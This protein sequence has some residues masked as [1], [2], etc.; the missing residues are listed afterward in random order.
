[1]EPGQSAE[2]SQGTLVQG[3][4]GAGMLKTENKRVQMKKRMHQTGNA[5]MVAQTSAGF[6]KCC[7]TINTFPSLRTGKTR[8]T[9]CDKTGTFQSDTDIKLAIHLVSVLISVLYFSPNNISYVTQNNMNKHAEIK[10]L[11]PVKN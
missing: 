5:C 11:A 2:S 3:L 8:R 6:S 1:M 10:I 9:V 7:K 4:T